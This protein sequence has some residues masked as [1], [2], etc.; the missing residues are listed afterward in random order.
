MYNGFYFT[1]NKS[2]NSY[3]S[4]VEGPTIENKEDCL[5]VCFFFAV[6]MIVLEYFSWN[7]AKDLYKFKNRNQAK[8][9][10]FKIQS[11]IFL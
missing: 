4:L 8:A 7:I 3:G 5:F 6:G 10:M 9:Q 1:K 2:S 11:S